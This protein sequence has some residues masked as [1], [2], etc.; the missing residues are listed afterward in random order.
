MYDLIYIVCGDTG[1]GRSSRDIQYLSGQPTDLAHALL[2][3]LIEDFDLVTHPEH[4][5]TPRN[6]VQRII[7]VLYRLGNLPVRRE[8]VDGAQRAGVGEGRE[9]V[10]QPGVWI[11]FR[12]NF[13]GNEFMEEVTLR[14][15]QRL[16]CAL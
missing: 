4:A 10:V 7:G 12:D 9:W 5:L 2:A 6:A 3:L 1:L 15:M 14:F 16:M 8:G 11:G 13:R